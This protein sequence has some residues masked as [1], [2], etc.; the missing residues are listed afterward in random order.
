[1]PHSPQNF[2]S[3]GF[4][5]LQAKHR[6]GRFSESGLPAKQYSSVSNSGRKRSN[7]NVDERSPERDLLA[8]LR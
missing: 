8:R 2:E 3:G 5:R 4:S 7:S 6:K 1:M